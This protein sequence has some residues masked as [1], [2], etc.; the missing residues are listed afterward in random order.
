MTHGKDTGMDGK[1]D[2]RKEAPQRS[3]AERQ[4]RRDAPAVQSETDGEEKDSPTRY[5]DWASI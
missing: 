5:R 3:D 2:T 4:P 1:D